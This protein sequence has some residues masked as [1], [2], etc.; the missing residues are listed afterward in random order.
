MAERPS[1]RRGPAK[2]APDAAVHDTAD[3]TADDTD[4]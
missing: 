4:K 2:D 1:G 3:D